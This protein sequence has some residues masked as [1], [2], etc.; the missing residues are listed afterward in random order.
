M[1]SR[2]SFGRHQE[3]VGPLL[4]QFRKSRLQL[5]KVS[6]PYGVKQDVRLSVSRHVSKV[7]E[8]EVTSSRLSHWRGYP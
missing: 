3:C 7:P 1:L 4:E 2:E 8:A 6:R 5:S